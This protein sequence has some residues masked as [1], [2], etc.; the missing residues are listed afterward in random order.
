MN[1]TASTAARLKRYLPLLLIAAAFFWT[2][3]VLF[4]SILPYFYV[5]FLTVLLTHR[6]V[7][8]DR[9]C[10]GKYGEYW[11]RYREIVPNRIIPSFQEK[12]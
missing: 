9:R 8:D 12:E 2:V 3:P 5:I 7:L 1:E 10:A 11:D 4:G 6:S